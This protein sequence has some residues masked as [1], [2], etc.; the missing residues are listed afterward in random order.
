VAKLT[1]DQHLLAAHCDAKGKMWS[2][3]RLFRPTEGFAGLNAAACATR[4]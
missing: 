3:L 4:S 2:N 1:D